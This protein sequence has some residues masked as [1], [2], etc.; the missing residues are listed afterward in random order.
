MF[1]GIIKIIKGNNYMLVSPNE[2]SITGENEMYS[3]RA[4]DSKTAYKFHRKIIQQLWN[5]GCIDIID[6]D[7]WYN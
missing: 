2:Y 6:N 3:L 1:S 4:M 5:S 7:E